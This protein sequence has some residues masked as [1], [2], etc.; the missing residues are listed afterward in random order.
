MRARTTVVQRFR[1][2]L[3]II[4]AA[5]SFLAAYLLTVYTRETPA[6]GMAEGAL[7]ALTFTLVGSMVWSERRAPERARAPR[8][9]V[10]GLVAMAGGLLIGWYLA[11]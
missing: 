7:W 1:G 5:C 6:R 2:R 11:R 8:T 3:Q 10:I 9:A 4:L